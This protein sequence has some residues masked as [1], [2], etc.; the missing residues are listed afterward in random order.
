MGARKVYYLRPKP[1]IDQY[2]FIFPT[3]LPPEEYLYDGESD[4]GSGDDEDSV[5]IKPRRQTWSNKLQFVLACVGYSVGLGS[6]WRFPYLCYKSG[7]GVFLIPYAIIMIVCGVPMLYMELS[8]GQYTGRGPIGALGHLCPLLK[9]TGLGSVVISFLMSTYYSVIIAYGIYYFFTSFKAKQPWEDCSHR[10]NTDECWVPGKSSPS[11]AKPNDSQTPAEQFYDKKVLQIGDGIEDFDSLRWEL[12]ACLLCA[13]VMVYFAIWKSIKSSAKVRYFT[14]TLPFLLIIVFLAKS[15]TLEGADKGMRYF[16]KPKFQLLLDAKVWVNAAAQTFNSMGIAFGS[17][18]SFASYSKYNN[19]IL[20]DTLAVSFVNA[21]TSL[22]VGIFAFAT[23]GNI[24]SEQGTSIEA[25]IDDGPGLIFV[26]Y[27][28]AMAKMPAAQL[29]AVLFFFMLICLALNSQFAIVEVVVTSIQDGFP[30]WIKKHLMCHEVLVLIICVVSLICG[31]PNVTQG[32]IYFFQLIDHY[33]ASISIMYLAF[34]EV[35][36]I[37]WFYGVTRLSKNVKTMTGRQPSLY[38]KF[39]WLIATP[40]MIFSVWVFC[41]IDYESP[42]YN[43]GEYHYPIW[44]IVIG[45]I[46]SA[47]SILCIPIYMVYV[48]MKS[49][50]NTFMEKLKSSL[51]SDLLDK[52][53]KCEEFDCE[54]VVKEGEIEPMLVMHK[55]DSKDSNSTSVPFYIP[56]SRVPTV[57]KFDLEKVAVQR[58][59]FLNIDK[60]QRHK[61]D[62]SKEDVLKNSVQNGTIPEEDRLQADDLASDSTNTEVQQ[63]KDYS[64][65]S[66][67]HLVAADAANQLKT[68]EKGD[69]EV[70]A[71][72]GECDGAK[73]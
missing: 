54:C 9:G 41:M 15:L 34:F 68:C 33:A 20:H 37:A 32:G 35:I 43:N 56:L 28:Q 14:A 64:S 59:L 63:E 61:L 27:P 29:W 2:G 12:V 46:I 18:I 39:C 50:G 47:L 55:P 5:Y 67:I 57:H 24:A 17:M 36:A 30:A 45:W 60:V 58:P 8:V 7:G 65:H 1:R 11:I 53:P 71:N 66:N 21:I 72:G 44:A 62:N 42:T 23:I 4:D 40:L 3:I 10:W 73:E 70:Q 25:V 49:P 52:C 31:L 22:L 6:V 51:K 19:N 69:G 26:V 48:F 13:W 16:F 38:F